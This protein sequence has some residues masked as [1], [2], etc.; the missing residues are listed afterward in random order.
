VINISA[1]TGVFGDSFMRHVYSEH[2]ALYSRLVLPVFVTLVTV[3]VAGV[4]QLG[5]HFVRL[6][7]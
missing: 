2:L 6:A 4:M 3:I 1:Y 5:V 7:D